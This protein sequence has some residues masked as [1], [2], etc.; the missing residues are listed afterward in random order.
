MQANPILIRIA[1]ALATAALQ[2]AATGCDKSAGPD[3][4]GAACGAGTHLD[5]AKGCVPDLNT[6]CP[7]GMHFE[8]GKGCLASVAPAPSAAAPAEA[9]GAELV[10][11]WNGKGCQ[12]SGQCWTIKVVID[13]IREQRPVGTIAYPSLGCEARLEFTRWEGKDAV[14][15]EQYTKQGQCAPNGTLRL[16]V[17]DAKKLSYE[18]AY[19]DGRVDAVTMLELQ[20]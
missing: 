1:V 4:S 13:A 20:P 17:V 9:P 7:A 11:T 14:F 16:H 19:P 10:G 3:P 18:W 15:M 12:K 5:G 2:L 8:A 6:D